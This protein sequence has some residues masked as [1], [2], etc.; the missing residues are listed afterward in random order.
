MNYGSI[1]ILT[2]AGISAESGIPTF[3]ADDGLWEN[4][5]VTEI[6]TP[7]G[8]KK[9]PEK[10][11]R[12]YNDRRKAMMSQTIRPNPAHLALADLEAHYPGDVYI[13]T[14]NIDPL[15]EIAGSQKVFHM[16]G[17]ILKARCIKSDDV[18]PWSSAFD[19]ETLCPCCQEPGRLRPHIV[20]FGEMP[21][22]ME[23][24]DDLL[25]TCGLFIS[26]GTSGE[27]YPAAGFVNWARQNRAY[28]IELNPKP[29]YNPSF[30]TFIEG[31]A[32][33]EVPN[34]VRSILEGSLKTH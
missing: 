28:C 25:E 30:H 19:I 4:H 16:H 26:I 14:Q 11:L 34:L 29:T 23:D 22:H 32:G 8:F 13:V 24:I 31:T 21:F 17:E 1:V 33:K 20:W 15:H 9:D 2:G 10:V 3:R 7:S 18:F 27:V 6:A 12:F 5:K